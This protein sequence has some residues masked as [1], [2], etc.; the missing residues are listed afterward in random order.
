[1]TMQSFLDY[2]K[3]SPAAPSPFDVLNWHERFCEHLDR[4]TSGEIKRLMVIAPGRSSKTTLVSKL[5]TR[6]V[7]EYTDWSIFHADYSLTISQQY[8]RCGDYPA[9]DRILY[10]HAGAGL[11]GVGG[12]RLGIVDWANLTMRAVTAHQWYQQQF[13][14]RRA[15]D[16]AIIYLAA[17]EDEMC[18]LMMSEGEWT[19]LRSEGNNHNG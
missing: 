12:Y 9:S 7:L 15:K 14:T 17:F 19:V 8:Q 3:Q 1:M 2:C 10:T 11:V 16:A 6:Y 18:K 5:Y 13:E 4:V